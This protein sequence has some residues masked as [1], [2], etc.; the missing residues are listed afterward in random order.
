MA[1]CAGV[2]A[3]RCRKGRPGDERRQVVRGRLQRPHLRL[4]RSTGQIVWVRRP[5]AGGLRL[6]AGSFYSTPAIAFGRLYIGSTDGGVYSLSRALARRRRRAKTGDYVYGSP[7]VGSPGGRPSVFVGP[8]TAPSTPSMPA[9][10]AS[11]G[12][13]ISAADLRLGDAPRRH[14]LDREPR[15]A[16]HVRAPRERR[17]RR[18]RTARGLYTA[19]ISDG[20]PHLPQ[21]LHHPLRDRRTACDSSAAN[22]RARFGGS[23]AFED[24]GVEAPRG[25]T[26]GPRSPGER[27]AAP[28]S[29]AAPRPARRRRRHLRPRP[30]T[31][32]AAAPS[33][34]TGASTTESRDRGN[35]PLRDA[36]PFDVTR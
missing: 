14:R 7:A 30:T 20:P 19:V 24:P 26:Q 13:A 28:A 22:H 23:G 32:M 6:R 34:N 9:R 2:R 18:Y 4:P 15:Q 29:S 1:P 3:R 21:R 27:R 12:R 17:L 8:T 11:A 36:G 5:S 16:V 35:E 25:G 31:L 33:G 10:D